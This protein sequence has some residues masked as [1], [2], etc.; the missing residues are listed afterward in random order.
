MEKTYDFVIKPLKKMTPGNHGK[1]FF[2]KAE[3]V[4]IKIVYSKSLKKNL[5]SVSV[6]DERP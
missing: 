6:D 1:H 2:L 5:S 4:T 3:I